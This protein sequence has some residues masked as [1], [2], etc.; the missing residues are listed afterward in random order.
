MITLSLTLLCG[1]A[2]LI[3]LAHYLRRSRSHR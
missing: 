2:Y 1:G 3:G